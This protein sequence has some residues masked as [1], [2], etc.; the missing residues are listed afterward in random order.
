MGDESKKDPAG[1]IELLEG[2]ATRAEPLSPSPS[3]SSLF[4]QEM[5]IWQSNLEAGV[6]MKLTQAGFTTLHD[7][8]DT[9]PVQLSRG[10][11]LS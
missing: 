10:L 1:V 4:F 2:G 7:I 8:A 9:S 11:P 5:Q 6:K 3:P